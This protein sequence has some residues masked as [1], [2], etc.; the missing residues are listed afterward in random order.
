MSDREQLTLF[1]RSASSSKRDAPSSP[2]SSEPKPSSKSNSS[3]AATRGAKPRRAKAK[4][5]PG[6]VASA[7]GQTVVVVPTVDYEPQQ[8]LPVITV[9]HTPDPYLFVPRP[10]TLAECRRGIEARP[11]PWI[12]CEAHLAMEVAAE[13]ASSRSS[14]LEVPNES[15]PSSVA[16]KRRPR[17]LR[18][19]TPQR[20]GEHRAGRRPGLSS[21][22]AEALV[23]VWLD[24]AI[25]LVGTLDYTCMY[26]VVEDHPDGVP[27]SFIAKLF[28]VSEQA[29]EG[30]ERQD[31]VR[32][33]ALELYRIK[34]GDQS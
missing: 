22:A 8:P 32:E 34:H 15:D 28:G 10:R 31:H 7:D 17:T 18:L 23:R 20:Q 29:I 1:A 21:S 3:S 2:P 33:A 19:N 30:V 26:D 6:T 12:G 5:M 24:D 27:S 9:R 16:S 14:A 4:R 11:C 25:E 13:A